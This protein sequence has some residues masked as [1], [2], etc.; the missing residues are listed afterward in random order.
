MENTIKIINS[1]NKHVASEKGQANQNL[2][3]CE[4]CPNTR[5]FSGPYFPLFGLHTGKYG[6]DET[7]F[8]KTFHAVLATVETLLTVA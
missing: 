1:N 7:P 2:S 5:F 4:K 3:L 8:L 6:L